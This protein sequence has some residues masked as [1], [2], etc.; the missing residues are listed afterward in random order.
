MKPEWHAVHVPEREV[1][2]II[3][4]VAE[5]HEITPAQLLCESHEPRFAWPRQQAM[6]EALQTGKYS[7]TQLGKRFKRHHTTVIHGARRHAQRVADFIHS[8]ST[9]IIAPSARHSPKRS[10]KQSTVSA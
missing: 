7:T 10:A 8:A 6:W 5:A 2:A 1:D 9:G 4:R 3:R